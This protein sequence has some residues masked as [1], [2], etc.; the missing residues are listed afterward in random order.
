MNFLEKKR[1]LELLLGL[2]EKQNGGTAN[3]LA[4]KLCVSI[5]TIENYLVIL[6]EAGHNIGFCSRRKTYYFF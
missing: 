1:K 6:R 5:P 2:I 4:E 3:Q